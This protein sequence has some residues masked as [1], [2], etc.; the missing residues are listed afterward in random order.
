MPKKPIDYSKTKMY[1]IA[2]KDPSI[3]DEYVGSTTDMVRRRWCHKNSC[4]I[5]KDKG[6][7]FPVYVHIRACGGWSNWEMT[8]IEDFP[9]K[10]SEEQRTRER[11][12]LET[13]GA[14]LN[15]HSPIRTQEENKL[16]NQNRQKSDKR[17]AY[18]VVYRKDNLD[19]LLEKE[20]AYRQLHQAALNEKARAS[21]AERSTKR[22]LVTCEC[23]TKMN[24][25]SINTHRKSAK[26]IEAM[27]LK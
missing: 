4:N 2:C 19:A 27:K 25:G 26:H 10:T 18:E 16:Y 5:E 15:A 14:K 6:Y 17:K 13:L 11:F 20:K 9:C 21:Y 23:G 12:W 7:N 8:V 24:H 3:K 22:D 1:K